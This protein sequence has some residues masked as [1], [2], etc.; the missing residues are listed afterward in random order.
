[1]KEL[2]IKTIL[3]YYCMPVIPALSRLRQE[4]Y[5]FKASLAERISKFESSLGYTLWFKN[6][7]KGK[8]LRVNM[9]MMSFN[10]L[11]KNQ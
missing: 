5:Y 10:K 1:M 9:I 11:S 3:L 6:E 2:I 4:N 7:I 8:R